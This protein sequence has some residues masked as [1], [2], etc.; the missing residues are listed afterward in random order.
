[1][2]KVNVGMTSEHADRSSFV[3]VMKGSFMRSC[4]HRLIYDPHYFRGMRHV[5]AVVLCSIGVG[6][7]VPKVAIGQV[8]LD[9]FTRPASNV[10]GGLWT[11]TETTAGTGATLNG[12][13]QLVLSSTASGRDYVTQD[14]SSLYG[15]IFDNNTCLMTWA[16]CI[17]QSRTDPSGFVAGNYGVA[18]V[19]GG[20]SANII[21]WEMATHWCMGKEGLPIHCVLSDLQEV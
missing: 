10:V 17:R 9:D 13:G 20:S 11:E 18:F 21:P 8:L 5:L 7:L 16:F 1:M 4:L 14:G 12:T 6:V 3:P 15:T 19:L 2:R